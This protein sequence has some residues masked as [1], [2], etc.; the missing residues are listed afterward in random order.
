MVQTPE[1]LFSS[2]SN[3]IVGLFIGVVGTVL[4]SHLRRVLP[5]RRTCCVGSARPRPSGPMIMGANIGTTVTNTLVSL[6]HVRQSQ[7]SGELFCNHRPRLLQLDGRHHFT[8]LRTSH[9]RISWLASRTAEILTG[10]AV[11]WKSPIKAWVK[12]PVSW[13]KIKSTG[14]LEETSLGVSMVVIGI[15]VV[16][17]SLI[18]VTKNMKAL[19]AERLE[20]SMNRVLRR[21]RSCRNGD[22]HARH[23]FGAVIE[24]HDIDPH[25]DGGRWRDL[26]SQ[27]LPG[28]ARSKRWYNDHCLI[29]A[30]AASGSDA[31]T[32]A[33]VHTV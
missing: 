2:V 13:L 20:A 8:S 32:I 18:A 21:W 4:F 27:Y 10:S 22:W 5:H 28:H 19:I 12:H 23:H 17:V 1:R 29:A 26:A 33:L 25:P 15:I 16:V 30:L 14:S 24:H 3:P 11:Q 6:G 7:G 9:R 31:L